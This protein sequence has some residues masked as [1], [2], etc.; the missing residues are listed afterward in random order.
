V[1]GSGVTQG[2]HASGG[3]HSLTHDMPPLYLLLFLV[4]GVF[5]ATVIQLQLLSIAFQKLGLSPQG[6]LLLMLGTLLGSSINIPVAKVSTTADFPP[7][8][9]DPSIPRRDRRTA[10]MTHEFP[11]VY[12]SRSGKALHPAREPALTARARVRYPGNTDTTGS[13]IPVL[14]S[15]TITIMER[16]R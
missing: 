8:P 11:P 13:R 7:E 15:F 2:S 16:S 10:G 1:R 6:A 3:G 9:L 4:L 14:L 5:L 12:I